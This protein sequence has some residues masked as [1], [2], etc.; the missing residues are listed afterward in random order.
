MVIWIDG[1]MDEWLDG[2]M[3]GWIDVCMDGW[4]LGGL[5]DWKTHEDVD[6]Y[7]NALQWAKSS[8]AVAGK[9]ESSFAI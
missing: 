6:D 5:D 3:D 9:S 2:W 4:L 8:T 1:W 7:G